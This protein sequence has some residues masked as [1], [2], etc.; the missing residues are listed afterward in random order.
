VERAIKQQ[1][2]ARN[3]LA[4]YELKA[5]EELRTVE[6]EVLTRLEAKYRYPTNH[7]ADVTEEADFVTTPIDPQPLTTTFEPIQGSLF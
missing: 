2:R 7:M 6:M 4:L 3:Y 5:A 1:V